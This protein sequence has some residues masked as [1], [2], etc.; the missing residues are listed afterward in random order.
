LAP[1]VQPGSRVGPY[2]IVTPIGAGGMGQV[3]LA[4]DP[5]LGR[6]VAIKSLPD[7]SRA[8]PDRIARFEREARILASLNHPH[9]AAI[10]GLEDV[11][12]TRYLILELVEGGTLMERLARGP[13]SAPEA[14]S[15]ACQVAD[16]LQ[17]AHEKGIIHRDLKPGNIALTADG[18]VKVLDFGLA[19][20]IESTP[21]SPTGEF[22]ATRSG[23]I[24]GT[25]A[26]MSPE[27][28]RG[29][30]LDKRADIW[31]FGCVLYELL[32]GR[33][34]FSGA[35]VSERITA[36][37][38]QEPDWTALPGPSA[39]QRLVRRCLQK[40]PRRRQQDI[41][42]ARIELEEA[43]SGAAA[44]AP[45]KESSPALL[46][47]GVAARERAAW[48]VAGVSILALIAA[49]AIGRR[50]SP[51]GSPP[52][53]YSASVLL[54][55][56]RL[57]GGGPSGRF[58]LSPDGSR[59]A[60]A[61]TDSSGITQLY[62]R[63]L[64]AQ[65][66]QPLA[67]TDGA[68]FPFWSPD[69]RFVAFLAGGLLKKVDVSGGQTTTLCEA[70]LSSTGA[71][72]KGGVILFT[73]KGSSPLYRV[74]A[75]GG[76]PS[77]ATTLD[78]SAGDVQHWYP[79]FL[80]DGRHF[81]YFV[82]GSKTQGFTDPRAVY[83]GSLDPSEPH[84]LVLEGGTNAKYANDHL[85]YLRKGTLLAQPFDLERLELYGDAVPLVE[86]VQLAGASAGTTGMAGAISV[87]ETGVL[88]YQAGLGIR[89]QLAW[90]DR[91]GKP[92]KLLGEPG[93]I[94]D[95][96]L[97]PDDTRAAVSLLDAAL[98]T[99]DV[100]TY[101]IARGLPERLTFDPGDDFAPIWSRP[102]GE[103]I[104]YSSRRQGAIHLYETGA[105][106]GGSEQLVFE[107]ALGKFASHWS[108]DGRFIAY[109][110]GG[111]IIGRSDLWILPLFGDRKAYAFLEKTYP[112]SQPQFSP[113]GRWVAYM[114]MES[115]RPQVYVRPF[116][117]PGDQWPVSPAGGG[118]PRWRRDQKELFY[119]APDGKI[120][121][122]AV[123]VNQGR[124]TSGNPS[125]AL[126]ARIRS[127]TRL[128]AYQY[129][130]A[131]DGQR[132]IL[133]AFVDGA[134]DPPITLLVNWPAKLKQ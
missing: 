57:W 51:A 87:S 92:I 6:D 130:V 1:N 56:L 74:P 73:P 80:P 14:L 63:P 125:V 122:A 42:D 60:I 89:S 83:V 39:V 84:K 104:V 33:H 18:Q 99:R 59:L 70:T 77:P 65:V 41:G 133:N 43:Q 115:G 9:I 113:D 30:P 123:A 8:D 66:A 64:N 79:H 109:V 27:Q 94:A 45:L 95:V 35:S 12:A 15:I 34:P 26:Y 90:Y 82:V 20:A 132:F 124:F 71:W 75:A 103:R 112:E 28:A 86:Q 31:A 97:S 72:G 19:K 46:A 114:T 106:P 134:T 119:V 127:V 81:L 68:S 23:V 120:M 116:S 17:A 24:L 5:R 100:W 44:A 58:A 37:L 121:A 117:G 76:A 49:L 21:E 118:W 54:P 40:E 110:G 96:S 38:T 48:I 55:D 111:G 101:D 47:S 88:A 62:V 108:Y 128:D 11:G 4:R 107:D 69:S 129:D 32:T 131:S 53:A 98:G 36:I 61:A 7:L 52:Q 2:Q 25:A 22:E 29:L 102:H 91:S 85:V 126:D 67:G 3:Y 50:D 93:D 78:A 16:A 13:L 105:R 10:Y